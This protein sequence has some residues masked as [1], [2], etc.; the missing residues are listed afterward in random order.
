[1]YFDKVV[2]E[3]LRCQIGTTTMLKKEAGLIGNF[4]SIN[5]QNKLSIL[6]E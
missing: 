3:F 5:K 2:I 4:D 1:M 6:I